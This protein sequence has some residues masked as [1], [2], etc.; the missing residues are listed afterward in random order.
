MKL[1]KNAVK[2]SDLYYSKIHLHHMS[3]LVVSIS[4]MFILLSSV[5]FTNFAF[6][7]EKENHY[8]L[9]IALALNC[10]FTIDEARVIA[11]GDWNMD[12]DSE[13]A[14]VR[15]GS[16][17]DNPKWKW[18]A[19]PTEDPDVDKNQPSSGNQQIKQ[20]QHDLYNRAL[21]EKDTGMRLFKFGQYLHY[22][23]DKWSH[24]GYTTGIGHALPNIAPGMTSPDQTHANP[25]TY[26][27]MVFDSMVNLGKLAKS[28]GKD[29][30]CVSDLV[31]LD[32]YHGSPEYGKDFPWISPQ[33]IKRTDA[34]KFKKSV[35]KHLSDWGKTTLIN[36]VID[37]SKR[38]SDEGVT[39]SFISYISDKTGI[40]KSD[41]GKKYDYI[42]VDIDDNGDAK[43]LPDN[44][45]KFL[46]SNDKKISSV[47]NNAK[48]NVELAHFQ[49]LYKIS[50][51]T[52]K[53]TSALVTANDGEIKMLKKALELAKKDRSNLDS[54][55]TVQKIKVQLKDAESDKKDLARLVDESKQVT[56][57]I[58]DTA[59]E[60]GIK[61]GDLGKIPSPN[62]PLDHSMIG[63]AL[64]DWSTDTDKLASIL[65]GTMTDA[66][67]KEARDYVKR[68]NQQEAKKHDDKPATSDA[69]LESILDEIDDFGG[70]DAKP[71]QTNPDA[72]AESILDDISISGPDVNVPK[73]DN[74]KNTCGSLR[75]FTIQVGCHLRDETKDYRTAI[76]V[77]NFG[78]TPGST[79]KEPRLDR[80]LIGGGSQTNDNK[81]KTTTSSG[82]QEKP[83][84]KVIS[85][86][87]PVITNTKPVMTLPSKYTL[88]ATGPSGTEVRYDATAQDKEDGFIL[89]KCNPDYGSIFPIGTTTVTCTTKDSDGNSVSGTFTVIV[90]DTTPPNIPAFQPREGVRDDSGVQVFFD[91]VA[92]DLVDGNVPANCNYPSGYKFPIGVTILTCTADDSRGNHA[93]RS[94]QITVTIKESGQ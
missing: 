41:V 46:K 93:T 7:Y 52:E 3:R 82:A 78:V 56:K 51:F 38:K 31:P 25:E 2:N 20:R 79:S 47:K 35:D 87:N 44:L 24:W 83:G 16:G 91:V 30:Q 33:E 6:A 57:K 5:T 37:V 61:K 26:R 63:S 77:S 53:L 48:S 40:S 68:M 72:P 12:E 42:Y 81:P 89:P 55:K 36:E 60:N 86:G 50:K 21:N 19:L 71:S 10:G 69:P 67:K 90:R 49:K 27:Y 58:A 13:T 59:V 4:L 94:L 17:T 9:K 32:T 92:V 80:V 85:T 73:P 45:I 28:L 43:K 84:E 39:E 8:W 14:P 65:F 15:T 88:E 76:D 1:F 54:Q 66:D 11:T 22:E 18:H 70:P 62:K 64:L 75:G 29:T 23:E 74:S 34:D